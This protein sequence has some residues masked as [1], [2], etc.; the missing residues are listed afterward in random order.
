MKRDR[1]IAHLRRAGVPERRIAVLLGLLVPVPVKVEAEY[2]AER[3]A[4]HVAATRPSPF[5]A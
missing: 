1:L 5:A 4:H 3:Y 2:H